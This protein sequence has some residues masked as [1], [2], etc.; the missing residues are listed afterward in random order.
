MLAVHGRL[1]ILFGLLIC[2]QIGA[3]LFH[4]FVREDGVLRRMLP[5]LK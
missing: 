4:Y 1:A 2:A 3:A 5:G